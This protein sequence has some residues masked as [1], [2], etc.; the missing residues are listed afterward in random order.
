ML[1]S[2]SLYICAI[3]YL[4]NHHD[5]PLQMS[6]LVCLQPPVEVD[7]SKLHLLCVNNKAEMPRLYS[8]AVMP[9]HLPSESTASIRK[10]HCL[11]FLSFYRLEMQYLFTEI[12]AHDP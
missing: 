1:T 6:A 7:V 5:T 8:I 10:D 2:A 4:A 9:K 11:P 3:D 12:F